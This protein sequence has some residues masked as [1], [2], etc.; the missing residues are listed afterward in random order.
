LCSFAHEAE[1]T[2]ETQQQG[3]V[4]ADVVLEGGAEVGDT[5]I[6]GRTPT[7]LVEARQLVRETVVIELG[8][9]KRCACRG[10]AFAS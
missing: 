8:F 10:M 6:V 5:V 3:C 2:G 1:L 4:D 9:E 7:S